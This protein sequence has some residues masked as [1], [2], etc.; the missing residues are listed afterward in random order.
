MNIHEALEQFHEAYKVICEHFGEDVSLELSPSLENLPWFLT[1]QFNE[2]GTLHYACFHMANPA[3]FDPEDEDCF[4]YSLEVSHRAL[5]IGEEFTAARVN[6][7]CGHGEPCVIF[8][9]KNRQKQ[10]EN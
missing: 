1:Q 4:Q 2:D 5:W 3:D 7:G 6:D 10:F 9:N 8:P